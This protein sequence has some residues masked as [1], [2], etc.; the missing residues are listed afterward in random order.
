[1]YFASN[2]ST[3]A[4]HAGFASNPSTTVAPASAAADEAFVGSGSGLA[5]G[6][7]ALEGAVKGGQGGGGEEEEGG[8]G[9]HGGGGGGKSKM[10]V[11][12]ADPAVQMLP[13]RVGDRK[14]EHDKERR[15]GVASDLEAVVAVRVVDKMVRERRRGGDAGE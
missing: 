7:E 2:A 14:L 10:V 1:M 13:P 8:V 3:T 11:S 9:K 15:L 6:R 5:Q 12:A 4:V